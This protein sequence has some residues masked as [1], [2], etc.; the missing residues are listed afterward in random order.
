MLTFAFLAGVA[1]AWSHLLDSDQRG[2]RLSLA[3][4]YRGEKRLLQKHNLGTPVET[5]CKLPVRETIDRI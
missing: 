4:S 3:L 5:V 2:V 1:D